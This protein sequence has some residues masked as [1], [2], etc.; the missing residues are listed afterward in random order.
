MR[1]QTPDDKIDLLFDMYDLDNDGRL[2]KIEIRHIMSKMVEESRLKLDESDI[3]KLSDTFLENG[4]KAS[5]ETGSNPKTSKISKKGFRKLL[6]QSKPIAKDVS[7]LIDHWIG[8]V[9]EEEERFDKTE[10]ARK[11]ERALDVSTRAHADTT[12][13]GIPGRI[14]S[15][16]CGPDDHGWCSAPQGKG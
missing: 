11:E 2:G 4:V 10:K 3:D 16:H 1:I 15:H 7:T 9:G 13:Y 5:I 12:F 8:A 14:H 6:R